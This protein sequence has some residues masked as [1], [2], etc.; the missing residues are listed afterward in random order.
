MKA[1]SVLLLENNGKLF[2]Y[3]FDGNWGL[4]PLT[5]DSGQVIHFDL[6]LDHAIY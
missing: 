5:V 4:I 1:P 3:K 6:T 2:S